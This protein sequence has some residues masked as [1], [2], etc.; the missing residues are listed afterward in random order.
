MQN[1]ILLSLKFFVYQFI[2]IEMRST[3]IQYIQQE[4]FLFLFDKNS[5]G[6]LLK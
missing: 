6:T 1:I 4:A 5:F 3:E 2:G